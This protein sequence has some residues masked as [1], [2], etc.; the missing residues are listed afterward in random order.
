LLY[1][2]RLTE[3]FVSPT[4]NSIGFTYDVSY[5]NQ[6]LYMFS[7]LDNGIFDLEPYRLTNG[8][9]LWHAHMAT[10]FPDGKSIVYMKDTDRSNILELINP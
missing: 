2:G 6:S 5:H 7:K 1:S 9:G 4:G 8:K 10:W 3:I